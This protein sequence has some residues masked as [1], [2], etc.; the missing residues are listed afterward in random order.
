MSANRVRLKVRKL[1]EEDVLKDVVRLGDA[2]R[3]GIPN[4]TICL[5]R[6]NR[7]KARGFVRGWGESSTGSEP[8]IGLD[9]AMR[10]KLGLEKDVEYDFQLI[11]LGGLGQFLW[12]LGASD[13]AVRLP[14]MLA[15]VSLIVGVIGFFLGIVSVWPK[16]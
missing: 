14:A 1:P 11:P 13:P 7:R 8:I 6:A 10:R 3:D 5:V 12:Y 15:L 16:G 2:Y 9:A 4:Q